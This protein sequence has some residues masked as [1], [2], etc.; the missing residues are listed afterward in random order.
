MSTTPHIALIA[1]VAE[2]GVI[3]KD[4]D[5]PWKVKGDWKYFKDKTLGKPIIMGRKCFIS[6]GKPLTNRPNI[7]IT[8]DTSFKAE[9]ATVTH[10]LEQAL[11]TAR[12]M[13][14]Q[15]GGDE[16]MVIGGSEI[17]RLALPLADRLYLNTI[18]MTAEGDIF[19]PEVD[20]SKWQETLSEFHAKEPGDS[21]D[22]TV[23]IYER[24]NT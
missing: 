8:R 18:H 23:R 14:A 20:F 13:L 3:G 24:K 6:L 15:N 19:F 1:A 12:D 11:E 9:G 7:V 5:L 4:N 16:I 22:Y 17:Y 2:N 21:A 10:S